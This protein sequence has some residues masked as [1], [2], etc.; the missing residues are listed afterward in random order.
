MTAFPNNSDT[1]DARRPQRKKTTEKH[2]KKRSG[3][4]NV[5]SRLKD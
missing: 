5:D 4:G 3:E 2:L 1:V